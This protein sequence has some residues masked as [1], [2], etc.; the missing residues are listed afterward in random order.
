M[1]T[2]CTRIAVLAIALLVGTSTTGLAHPSDWADIVETKPARAKPAGTVTKVAKAKNA[3]KAK[4]AT[5]AKKK[6]RKTSKRRR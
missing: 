4:K 6:A 2:S 1:V 5:K 3:K